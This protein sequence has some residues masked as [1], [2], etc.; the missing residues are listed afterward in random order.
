MMITFGDYTKTDFKNGLFTNY[1]TWLN[2][3]GSGTHPIGWEYRRKSEWSLFQTG[4]FGYDLKHGTGHG[5]DEYYSGGNGSQSDFLAVAKS[6]HDYLKNNNFY[7]VQGNSIPY[8]NGTS[9]TDCSAYVTWVLYEYGYTELKG[10][11][12]S[13]TWYMDK[14]AMEKKGWTVKP[15]TQAKAGDIVVNDY[16]MEIYAGDGKFYNAGSTTAMREEISNSGTG[17]LG[18]FTYAI[19]V[20][21]PK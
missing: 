12:K 13:T 11:Q 14:S 1:M 10:P 18:N 21:P 17:Y 4:Y 3:A 16:H 6:C 7:Y 19:T 8:P 15:A 2:Y 9:Y 20:T 5:M